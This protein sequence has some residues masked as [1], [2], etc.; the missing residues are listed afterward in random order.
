MGIG[1]R[2][3]RFHID[4]ARIKLGATTRAQAVA[5]ALA[6]GLLSP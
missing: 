2:T 6:L 4:N 3:A 5:A 1:E